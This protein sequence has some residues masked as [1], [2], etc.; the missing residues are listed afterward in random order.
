VLL[1]LLSPFVVPLGYTKRTLH[2]C[3]CHLRTLLHLLRACCPFIRVAIFKICVPSYLALRYTQKHAQRSNAAQQAA[4]SLPLKGVA[5][6]DVARQQYFPT[7]EILAAA[8]GAPPERI[9]LPVGGGGGNDDCSSRTQLFERLCYDNSDLVEL[10]TS[11]M[12]L[13]DLAASGNDVSTGI[14]TELEG[15]WGGFAR[16]AMC[17]A[18]RS[19]VIE[20]IRLASQWPAG[21]HLSATVFSKL[22]RVVNGAYNYREGG[23]FVAFG[24]GGGDVI[25]ERFLD[26]KSEAAAGRRHY[27]PQEK[28]M[29]EFT[30]V[31]L[32]VVKSMLDRQRI[33]PLDDEVVV[34]SGTGVVPFAV[35]DTTRAGVPPLVESIYDNTHLMMS[36]PVELVLV[37]V[38]SLCENS[39]T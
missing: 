39:E 20:G 9:A 10:A 36:A 25:G 18:D 4:L 21:Q 7:A 26:A 35:C 24:H 31:G 16:N 5:D 8:G 15:L 6:F 23:C 28:L 3:I 13:F 19:V 27:N 38:V 17:I 22:P 30:G 2:A 34:I 33:T 1:L 11:P 14:S 32:A 29:L 12:L 37:D